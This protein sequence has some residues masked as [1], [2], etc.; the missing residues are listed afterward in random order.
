MKF[1]HIQQFFF[2]ILLLVTTG[3][4]FWMLGS[5]LL[6]VFWALVTAIVFYPLYLRVKQVAG[7]RDSLASFLTIGAVILTIVVPIL[8]V[9]GMIA[10]ESLSV[11]QSVSQEASPKEGLNL[12]Q[13]TEA[14]FAYLEPYGIS[15]DAV[16]ERLRT[17]GAS[18]S[19]AVASS[20]VTMGQM[21]FSLL[22]STLI[23]LYLLFFLF[24][25][26]TKLQ[27]TLIYYL[28]LGDS[29]EKRLFARFTE[30]S[31]AVMKGTIAI[32]AL[33]GLLGGLTFWLVGISN[34]AMWG[35]AMAILSIV[36]AIGAALVWLPA[37]IILLAT[38]SIWEG[39]TM[40]VVGTFL[41]SLVDEFLRPILVGRGSRMPDSI[42]LL[43]TIG[44][45]ATFG[46]SGFVVGPII[47]AFF[48][49]LWTMFGEHYE[50]E[51]SRN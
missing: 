29:Y 1:A 21:T 47:A 33:Q 46:V 39:V 5:Y 48:L 51:L 32:A 8:L 42:T 41:V 40:L 50:K 44:G 34:P 23:M 18:A 3:T 13:Q 36:P 45:L 27:E 10:Q 38:G 11:Y 14:F 35:V 24:R 2:F 43:A 15:K 19:E 22:I 30:T 12:L 37:S 6:P 28:P 49:S 20:L 7:D 4:F 9:G 16:T 31:R 26:A 25:D 17:W